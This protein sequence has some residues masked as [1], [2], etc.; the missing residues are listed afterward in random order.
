M[1]LYEVPMGLYGVP[2]G[3]YGVSTVRYDALWALWVSMTPYGALW[4]SMGCYGSVWGLYKVLTGLYGALWG[5]MGRYGA[6]WGAVGRRASVPG[7]VGRGDAVPGGFGAP[8][9]AR[10]LR[11]GSVAREF[12]RRRDVPNH[13]P[14]PLP[15]VLPGTHRRGAPPWG[16]RS[17]Q[18][19]AHSPITTQPHNPTTP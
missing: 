4:V 2:M 11:Y 14:R 13:R 5:T 6:L 1:G 3:R 19:T 16:A 12:P 9:L 8:N 10:V 17:A 7:L 15:R 18:H